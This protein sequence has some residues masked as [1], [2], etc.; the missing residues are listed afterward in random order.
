[1]DVHTF[2]FPS[3]DSTSRQTFSF[4]VTE[5][6]PG[7][8][9]TSARGA[10]VQRRVR[11]LVVGFLENRGFVQKPD[12]ADF[13]V[14]IASGRR[15]REAPRAL[16]LPHPKPTGPAW[17][18]EHEEEDFVE[19]ILVIDVLDGKDQQ[20][21]WHGAARVQINPDKIDDDLLK[22]ATAKVLASFPWS[23]VGRSAP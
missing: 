16:P 19:G 21:L 8:Y 4:G 11:L 9:E 1:V 20:P 5:N 6:A 17:F 23:R 10:E 2:V 13:I 15:E 22:R 7:E 14:R 3:S 18:D 12:G